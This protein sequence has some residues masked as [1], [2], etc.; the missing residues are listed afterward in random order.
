MSIRFVFD[1][2]SRLC[3]SSVLHT[4]VQL[5]GVFHACPLGLHSVGICGSGT[6]TVTDFDSNFDRVRVDTSAGNRNVPEYAES[7]CADR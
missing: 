6:T 1:C 2:L 4:P 5:F 3:K 7:N